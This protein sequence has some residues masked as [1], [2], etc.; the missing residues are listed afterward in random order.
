MKQIK[1]SIALLALAAICAP[2][3]S[4]KTTATDSLV[5]KF[6][7]SSIYTILLNS[8]KQNARYE[9]EAA[10]AT[11]ATNNDAILGTVKTL[12]RTDAKK[13]ANETESGNIFSLPAQ[14][15]PTI[16]IPTQFNDHNLEVR[17]LDF[18]KLAAKVTP[19]ERDKYNPKSKNQKA[20][21]VAKGLLGGVMGA[22][23][24]KSESSMLRVDSV[25]ELLPAVLNK[26][27]QANNTGA[28][29]LAKWFAYDS[30]N[31]EPWKL[32]LITERGNY[33]FNQADL[34]R[35]AS[36]HSM[37]NKIANTGFDMINN[38]YV[39]AFNLRFRSYQAVVQ[40]AAALAKT[41]GSM[42]GGLGSLAATAASS[43]ASAA[44]GDGYTVQAVSHLYKLKWNDEVSNKFNENIFA[45]KASL[46]DLIAAGICE[47][48]FVG[49]E[50]ASANVRQS[51]LSDK[52][53]SHLVKR[54]TTRAID[55][56][57]AKLQAKNEVFRT[58]MPIIGGDGNGTIYA[59][60]GTKEGLNEKDEYEI[61]EAQEN[62]GRV[63]YKSVGS[64]KPVKG[65]IWNNV[66]GAEE[67]AAENKAKAD[68]KKGETKG[69]EFDDNA[70]NLGYTEFKGKKGDYT[71]YF[72]RL[73]KK[74]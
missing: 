28:N 63:T 26:Y 30:K 69:D 27:F 10:E 59:A 21:A 62:D 39:I 5:N 44:A 56:A 70:V 73:K 68:A 34:E 18:D 43:I 22:S 72:L 58:V 67:E 48:E 36:D 3:M 61:L 66:Y 52:P 42:F 50:K 6:M 54:A 49:K 60:I 41:A 31:S 13:A 24:G 35:A 23:A 71:G 19:E 57:I 1:K 11:A 51:I 25:D 12:A 32:D 4:A 37:A 8:E 7:R 47:L 45:K 20:G 29:L 53:L 9:T 15:F 64:V 2:V 40:E 65:K 55:S 74:K 46:E 14:L 38:T 16:E 33:N 17:V